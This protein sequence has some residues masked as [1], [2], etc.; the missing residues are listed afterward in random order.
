[1]E[2]ESASKI[3]EKD[4]EVVKRLK[5]KNAAPPPPFKFFIETASGNAEPF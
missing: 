5:T 2:F 1:M 4:L 3:K